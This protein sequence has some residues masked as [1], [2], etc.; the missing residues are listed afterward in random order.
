MACRADLAARSFDLSAAL[1]ATCPLPAHVWQLPPPPRCDQRPLPLHAEQL[2]VPKLPHF[3]HCCAMESSLPRSSRRIAGSSR[4]AD[5]ADRP[6]SGYA[7]R[8]GRTRAGFGMIASMTK[9]MIESAGPRA[10]PPARGCWPRARATP[11]SSS[12]SWTATTSA[13]PGVRRPDRGDLRAPRRARAVVRRPRLLA[14]PRDRDAQSAPSL[15]LDRPILRAFPAPDLRRQPIRIQGTAW[16]RFARAV[17]RRE[18][19]AW[20]QERARRDRPAGNPKDGRVWLRR[21]RAAGD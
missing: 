3:L 19:R 10:P 5:I 14:L 20:A 15:N 17:P 8:I 4:A 6:D 13:E 21:Q 11:G 9:A 1:V 2:R 16:P 18:K 7:R 12:A